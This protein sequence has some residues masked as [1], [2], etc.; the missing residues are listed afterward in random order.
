MDISNFKDKVAV[1]TGGSGILCSEMALHLA[2]LGCK[3]AVIGR[4]MDQLEKISHQIHSNGGTSVAIVA[5]VLKKEDLIK[6]HQIV[7]KKL[8]SCDILINGAG[9]NHPDATTSTSKF[10]FSLNDG[11][12]FFDLDDTAVGNVLHLNFMGSFIPLQIFG[13]DML[14]KKGCSII[15][16][17]S[18]SAYSPMTKVF[19]YSAAKAGISNFTQWMAVHFAETG[20]RVNAIAPGFFLTTQNKTLL[21]N[22]D[23]SLTERGNTI[24]SQTP[25]K[26]FGKPEDLLSTVEWLCSEQSSFV[27]GVVIP[28]DGGFN[29]FSG[30]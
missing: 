9:G 11:R 3:V 18:M 7:N 15:N 24:L 29:A 28:V 26:R 20:I 1:I 14:D 27:T 2:K 12:G 25:M 23:G 6:A 4:S 17:S 22:P 19:A 8:G 30:V 21:T 13:K 5:D 16:I 10:D